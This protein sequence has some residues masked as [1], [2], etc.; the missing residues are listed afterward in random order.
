MRIQSRTFVQQFCYLLLLFSILKVLSQKQNNLSCF[1]DFNDLD[2][3]LD[4]IQCK[5]VKNIIYEIIAGI[6]H[7]C[8][9]NFVEDSNENAQ[10]S[11]EVSSLESLNFAADLLKIDSAELIEAMTQ[12]KITTNSNHI[13][14]VLNHFH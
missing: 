3:A 1:N 8:N 6:L 13:V 10:I 9:I 4:A 2:Q 5:D 11:N 7:L 12:R 14:Y